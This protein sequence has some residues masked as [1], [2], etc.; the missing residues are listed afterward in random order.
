MVALIRSC[1]NTKR[2]LCILSHLYNAVLQTRYI[3]VSLVFNASVYERLIR[4]GARIYNAL[5]H[6]ALLLQIMPLIV[7]DDNHALSD[8]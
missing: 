6:V 4:I 7:N 8:A 5:P 3:L 1:L 2:R